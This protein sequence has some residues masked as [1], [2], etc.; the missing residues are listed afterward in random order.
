M[1]AAVVERSGRLI[2]SELC[3]VAAYRLLARQRPRS[4]YSLAALDMRKLELGGVILD[5]FERFSQITGE[6]I[7][8]DG[9]GATIIYRGQRVILYE[10]S[11]PGGVRR[12]NWTIAHEAGHAM[13]CHADSTRLSEVEADIFA[14]ELLM[15]EPAIRMLD[16]LFGAPLTPAAL[17]AWFNVSHS[18]AIRRR[19]ELDRKPYT[20][21]AA[22]RELTEL[23]FPAHAFKGAHFNASFESACM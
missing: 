12:L 22:G 17:T 15:P 19:D 23:L 18:A 10:G 21:S 5:T 14:S 3:A 2:R 1:S 9:L 20:P 7:A 13:M 6:C 16:A 11:A 8:F 4:I